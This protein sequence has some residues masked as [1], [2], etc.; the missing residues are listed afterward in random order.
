M[1]E[2]TR[3]DGASGPALIPGST[4][5]RVCGLRNPAYEPAVRTCCPGSLVRSF[6]C[7][8]YC[9]SITYLDQF[10][11]CIA[12]ASGE[13]NVLGLGIFCQ[14][15][16]RGSITQNLPSTS[17]GARVRNSPVGLRAL[18]WTLLLSLI[19]SAHAVDLPSPATRLV[20][21]QA[22]SS[23][24]CSVEVLRK[25]TSTGKAIEFAGGNFCGAEPGRYCLLGESFVVEPFSNNR[26]V[27][28][29]TAADPQYDAL[30]D[31]LEQFTG[32]K[33]PAASG[34]SSYHQYLGAPGTFTL[35]FTPFQVSQEIEDWVLS[36]R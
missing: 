23:S 11:T 33:F 10:A 22:S 19:L 3:C 20:S 6:E 12:T 4:L 32:R 36:S 7:I 5:G 9:D 18:F 30:F 15:E 31:Q 35:A 34:V 25:Y 27:N 2:S 8:R 14:D 17:E 21:R 1:S 13:D 16:T 26:T 28:G 24:S 29:T